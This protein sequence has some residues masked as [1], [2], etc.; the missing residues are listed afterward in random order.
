MKCKK[1]LLRN[2]KKKFV[3]NA[4][5]KLYEMKNKISCV[6]LKKKSCM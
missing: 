5:K 6:K 2:A 3:R 4:K 1:N